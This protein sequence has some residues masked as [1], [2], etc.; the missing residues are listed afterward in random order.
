MKLG[1]FHFSKP[2]KIAAA[3]LAT[4]AYFLTA[5]WL[6]RSY[7]PDPNF[8]FGP[9]VPGEKIRLLPPFAGH[10]GSPFAAA[11]ERYKLFDDLA[12]SPDN[13]HR[14]PIELYENGKRLGPAHSSHSDIATLGEGRFSHWRKN[15]TTIYWSSSDNTDPRTNGRAYWVLKP[16]TKPEVATAKP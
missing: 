3:T 13:N 14:S 5:Y 12:D 8:V 9:D 6:D 15:G 16:P 10:Q 1:P 4:G 2:A 11:K 7:Q